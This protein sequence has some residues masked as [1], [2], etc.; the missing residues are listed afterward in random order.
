MSLLV[1]NQ[2]GLWVHKL[3]RFWSFRFNRLVSFWRLIVKMKWFWNYV[4]EIWE[5]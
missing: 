1:V 3:V 2:W 5:F 4:A